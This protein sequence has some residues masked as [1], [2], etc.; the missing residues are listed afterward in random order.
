M[1]ELY[2]CPDARSF[3]CLWALE[4]LGLEYRLH[5]LPFP[6]RVK[7]PEYLKINPTGTIPLLL[8]GE[9]RMDES[10]AIIQY[11]AV[12][13]GPS[14][15]AVDPSEP[16]YGAWLNWLHFG[17][18]TLSTPL[19][20]ALRY[21]VFEPEERR[22]PEVADHFCKVFLNRLSPVEAKLEQAEYLCAGRF[23]MADISVGYSVQLCRALGLD[24]RLP[25]AVKDWW[26]R[27]QQRPGYKAARAAQKP[28]VTA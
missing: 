10:S 21:G 4:E 3:R 12:R 27:L 8:D 28:P 20:T 26:A 9:V 1:I 14:P 2:H 23:T 18:A 22:I 5:R 25:P 24:T 6:P 17:E 7:A 16:D 11:L 13:Y 15:L 19:A